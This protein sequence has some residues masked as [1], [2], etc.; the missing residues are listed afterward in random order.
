M[1]NCASSAHTVIHEISIPHYNLSQ[2]PGVFV[3]NA[4]S[5]PIMEKDG[6]DDLPVLLEHN[7]PGWKRNAARARPQRRRLHAMINRKVGSLFTLLDDGVL[8]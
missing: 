2:Q 5:K 4:P 7:G 3:E 6:K 8:K 1:W